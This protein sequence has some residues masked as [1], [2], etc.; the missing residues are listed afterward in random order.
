MTSKGSNKEYKFIS[1]D[2]FKN[3]VEK[4]MI[5]IA[6]EQ[7]NWKRQGATDL[8]VVG[9]NPVK[10]VIDIHSNIPKDFISPQGFD[11]N[12]VSTFLS[13][14]CE[15]LVYLAPELWGYE[16]WYVISSYFY[17]LLHEEEKK[18]SKWVEE[19]QKIISGK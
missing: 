17:N 6:G 12:D 4:I 15:D 2:D 14:F 11:Y 5:S 1:H 16:C 19:I 9:R 18:G 3:S 13:K 10:V 8:S 7:D